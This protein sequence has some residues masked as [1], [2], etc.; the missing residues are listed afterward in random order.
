LLVIGNVTDDRL[1]LKEMSRSEL[2]MFLEHAPYY[3]KY[4]TECHR[5]KKPTLLGKI[6]GV[7]K[8][9]HTTIEGTGA[10]LFLL[11]MEN[12]FYAHSVSH[13]FDL[14]GSVRN[15]L[16]NPNSESQSEIVLLDENLIKSKSR[17]QVAPSHQLSEF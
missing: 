17:K 15:R 8:V 9:A 2:M 7:Y 5:L 6:L 14:K 11:V 10:G 12:L 16:A 13:K 3:F 1:V 4:V